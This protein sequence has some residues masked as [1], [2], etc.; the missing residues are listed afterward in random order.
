MELPLNQSL[1]LL[2]GRVVNAQRA[3]FVAIDDQDTENIIYLDAISQACRDH[4]DLWLRID[5]ETVCFRGGTAEAIWTA[6]T[7]AVSLSLFD[8]RQADDDSEPAPSEP[9]PEVPFN[10]F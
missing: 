5:K 2:S 10:E 3:G 6:L 7:S 1:G 4:G 9:A 8:L